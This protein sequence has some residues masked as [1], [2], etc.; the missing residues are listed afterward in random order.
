MQDR[1]GDLREMAY[2]LNPTGAAQLRQGPSA[3]LEISLEGTFDIE[4]HMGLRRDE[5]VD[6]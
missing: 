4:A 1:L 2:Q 6:C 3:T 5:E